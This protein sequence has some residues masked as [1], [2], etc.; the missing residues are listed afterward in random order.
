MTHIVQGVTEII[1]GTVWE[2]LR[3]FS[4]VTTVQLCRMMFFRT[5]FRQQF[6]TR[7]L[8]LATINEQA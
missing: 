5:D 4:A 3:V 7:V 1:D 8:L 6:V 2:V